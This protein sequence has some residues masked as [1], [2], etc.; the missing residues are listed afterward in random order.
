M[1]LA[2]AQEA[3]VI[4]AGLIQRKQELNKPAVMSVNTANAESDIAK[5][6]SALQT[7]QTNYNK[8]E[9]DTAIGVDT[10]EAQTNV[11]SAISSIQA[12]SP[13]ILAS[14][15]IDTTS[16][17]TISATQKKEYFHP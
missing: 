16:A 17:E 4:L 9:V 15:G 10:T 1:S 13:E 3:Q 5:V 2:G 7:F 11:N 8:L 12:L 6:I 14:L